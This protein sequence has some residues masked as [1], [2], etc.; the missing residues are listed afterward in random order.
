MWQLSGTD[1][2]LA[3]LIWAKQVKILQA[4]TNGAKDMVALYNFQ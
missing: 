1:S 2:L 4:K 3:Y